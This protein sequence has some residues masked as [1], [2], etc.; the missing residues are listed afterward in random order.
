MRELTQFTPPEE[1]QP[2]RLGLPR[3]FD[4]DGAAPEMS[5]PVWEYE[6]PLV[7]CQSCTVQGS[8]TLGLEGLTR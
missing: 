1:V 5:K 3:G 8:Q 7:Q 2:G 4:D 6:S